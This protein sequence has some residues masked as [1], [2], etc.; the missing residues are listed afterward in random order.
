MPD[1]I[2]NAWIVYQLNLDNEAIKT[3][4]QPD[5]NNLMESITELSAV[6]HRVYT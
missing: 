3:L 2:D 5:I 1:G 6:V 4:M